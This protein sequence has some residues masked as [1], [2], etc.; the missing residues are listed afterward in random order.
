[1]QGYFLSERLDMFCCKILKIEKYDSLYF[2]V[3][4]ELVLLNDQAKMFRVFNINK[5][6]MKDNMSEMTSVSRRIVRVYLQANCLET[7]GV[8]ISNSLHNLV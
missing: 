2:V 5:E 1:M 4:I 7:Y 6:T 8:D 3:E